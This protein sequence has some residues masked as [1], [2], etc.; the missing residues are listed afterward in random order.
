MFIYIHTPNV[1][2]RMTIHAKNSITQ[3]VGTSHS[4]WNLAFLKNR[5]LTPIRLDRK[6]IHITMAQVGPHQPPAAIAADAAA[7]APPAIQQPITTYG[8][9]FASM[10]DAYEGAYLPFLKAHHPTAQ[11]P[12]ASVLQ[13]ALSLASHESLPGVYAYQVPGTFEIR[14][15]HHLAHANSLP[16]IAS[17]WDGLV[18]AFEG[19]VVPPGLINL[20][21]LPANAF[22]LTNAVITPTAATLSDRLAATPAANA[23]AGPFALGDDDV[24]V[25][26]TRRFMPVP[27]AYVT[28]MH[29]RALTPRQAWQVAEQVIADGRAADCEIFLDFLRAACT[30]RAPADP[31]DPLVAGA[32]QPTSM[33]VPLADAALRRQVWNWLV[34]DLPALATPAA[35]SIERQFMATTVAVRQELA[36]SRASTEAARAEAKAPKSVT[37]AYPT[38]APM[39]HRLCAVD[40]DADL[41]TFWREMATTSGKKH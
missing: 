13:T 7:A 34:L 15:V 24:A 40:N 17:P 14:T 41:P 19:D 29:D 35:E 16:G 28:F 38:V 39:L 26:T 37:G 30:Y 27:Y 21:Q 23:C 1:Q 5:V 8:A 33:T 12:P 31:V 2:A 36:L 3:D 6:L 20:V 25:V 10:G 9:K 4:F 11:L 18:F 32:A 22:H